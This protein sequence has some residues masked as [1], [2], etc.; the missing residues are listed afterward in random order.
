MYQW[1][2]IVAL[3]VSAGVAQA[4][5]SQPVVMSDYPRHATTPP[6]Q[7]QETLKRIGTALAGAVSQGGGN[8]M[9]QVSVVG[10]S[11]F[12]AQGRQFENGVSVDRAKSARDS[13]VAAF[14]DQA[15]AMMLG[16]SKRLLVSFEYSGRGTTESL[17]PPSASMPQRVLNRR[18]V[19]S[20]APLAI[21]RPTSKVAVDRC[22]NVVPA[23]ATTPLR[24]KRITCACNLLRNSSL[25]GDDF[26]SLKMFQDALGPRNARDL[27]PGEL[28]EVFRRSKLHY[29]SEVHQSSQASTGNDGEFIKQLERVDL[30][31]IFEIDQVQKQ[32][33]GVPLLH[34]LVITADIG[35]KTLDPNHIYSCYAWA[36]M[37]DIDKNR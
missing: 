5:V 20:W 27:T 25:A 7:H 10:H 26:Y 19:V 21:I 3:A 36:S 9:L 24:K 32:F 31:V 1:L 35:K 17:F 13:I 16:D 11:D 37:Q 15:N 8:S 2:F 14:N 29:R 12:D 30:R 34:D 6:A 33:A 23:S 28:T 18:V 22:A 4:Q